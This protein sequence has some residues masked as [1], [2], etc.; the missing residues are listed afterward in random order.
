MGAGIELSLGER[1]RVS[2]D[3]MDSSD[4]FQD[5]SEK[6]IIVCVGDGVFYLS[7][8]LGAMLVSLQQKVPL[9]LMIL[10]NK[11]LASIEKEAK[12]KYAL[13]NQHI[14]PLTDTSAPEIELHRCGDFMNAKSLKVQ[15]SNQLRMAL[16]EIKQYVRNQRKSFVIEIE[17]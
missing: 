8:V 9:V 3:K 10:N 6:I 13:Q 2:Y 15:N 17:Y 12:N 1:L 4:P 14:L 7:P 11:K 5:R 16:P